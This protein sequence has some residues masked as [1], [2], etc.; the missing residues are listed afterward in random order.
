MFFLTNSTKNI[1]RNKKRYLILLVIMFLVSLFSM[2]SFLI[3]N[4][5]RDYI[6]RTKNDFQR[7]VQILNFSIYPDDELNEYGFPNGFLSQYYKSDVDIFSDS[8]YVKNTIL[9]LKTIE[10]CENLIYIDDENDYYNSNRF[11]I[12]ANT[13]YDLFEIPEYQINEIKL[14]SGTM[15][16]DEVDCVINNE[17]AQ[18]NNIKLGDTIQIKKNEYFIKDSYTL[19]VVGF[20]DIKSYYTINATI[21]HDLRNVIFT[22]FDSNADILFT[23]N[24]SFFPTGNMAIWELYNAYDSDAFKEEVYSKGLDRRFNIGHDSDV[25]DSALI[26]VEN[27][28]FI[29]NFGV[30]ISLILG[31]ISTIFTSAIALRE[32]KYE[33]GILYSLGMTKIYIFASMFIEILIFVL[34]VTLVGFF[35]STFVSSFIIYEYLPNFK[36]V[37]ISINFITILQFIITTVTLITIPVLTMF[38]QI[39][40]SY[41][42]KLLQNRY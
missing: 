3:G 28:S 30:L 29:F 40:K 16:M 25:C 18:K 31:I 6:K 27:F 19:K 9:S 26:P 20:Y 4:A 37:L 39:I 2:T 8:K 34:S 14:V 41:P 13:T 24:S 11:L 23:V 12:D 38:L 15:Y 36:N 35:I 22:H 7:Y 17:L 42:L 21:N 1:I 5:C 10:N 33:I 32:R